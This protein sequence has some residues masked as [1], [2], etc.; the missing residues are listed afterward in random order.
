MALA[1]DE[2]RHQLEAVQRQ[3]VDSAIGLL[4]AN[5]AYCRRGKEGQHLEKVALSV[6]GFQHG[7]ARPTLHSDGETFADFALHTHAENL[8]NAFYDLIDFD[9]DI[10]AEDMILL[11]TEGRHLVIFI[12]KAG[13]D[14]VSIPKHQYNKGQMEAEALEIES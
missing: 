1:D 5:A 10:S 3:A 11:D 4:E 9:D 2:L 7:E 12:N 13:L 14:Y 6:A 8:Y